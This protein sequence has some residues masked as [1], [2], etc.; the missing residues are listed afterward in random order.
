MNRARPSDSD[1]RSV[2]EVER[3][4]PSVQHGRVA[5]FIEEEGRLYKDERGIGVK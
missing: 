4:G 3:A 5:R 2:G 1:G